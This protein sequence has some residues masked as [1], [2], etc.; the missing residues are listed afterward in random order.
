MTMVLVCGSGAVGLSVG[1]IIIKFY[2]R[3]LPKLAVERAVEDPGL[4]GAGTNRRWF[5]SVW[6]MGQA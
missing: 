5:H 4:R 1:I 2:Q 3:P 6:V